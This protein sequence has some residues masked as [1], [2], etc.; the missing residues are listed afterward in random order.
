[1]PKVELFLFGGVDVRVDGRPMP[2]RLGKKAAGLLV[3]LALPLGR[4]HSREELATL[5]WPDRFDEQARQSLRQALTAIRRKLADA[6]ACLQSENGEVWISADGV[7]SDVAAFETLMTDDK[8]TTAGDAT[9]LYQD[10][11]AA[12][13]TDISEEFDEWLG[14]ERT[15]LNNL[16]ISAF[17]TV[18]TASLEAEE[19]GAAKADAHKLLA[20]DRANETAHRALIIAEASS[21]HYAAAL[22]QY[23]QFETILHQELDVC[24]NEE[25]QKFAQELKAEAELAPKP[26]LRHR[27]STAPSAFRQSVWRRRRGVITAAA[28]AILA[29]TGYIYLNSSLTETNSS[30]EIISVCAPLEGLGH[31]LPSVMI[32]PFSGGGNT[33]VPL[34]LSEATR[35]ALMRLSGIAIIEGPPPTHPD[36]SLSVR[37]LAEKTNITHVIQGSIRDGRDSHVLRVWLS[38][39]QTGEVLS[40]MSSTFDTDAP[41]LSALQNQIIYQLTRAVQFHITDGPQTSAYK[42]YEIEDLEIFRRNTLAYSQMFEISPGN[43]AAARREYQTVL[44]QVPEDAMAHNG[45]AMT[46][47]IPVLMGWS[48]S[49]TEDLNVA[50][51]H[52]MDAQR[53]DP[54]FPYLYSSLGLIHLVEG[55]IDVAIRQ[56][57]KAIQLN[58]SNGDGLMI[59][60]YILTFAGQHDQAELMAQQALRLRPYSPPEWQVWAAARAMRLNDH[61]SDALRCLESVSA[62]ES[63]VPLAGFEYTAALVADEQADRARIFASALRTR[64]GAERLSAQTL[65]AQPPYARREDY[66]ACV[67]IFSRAG[68]KD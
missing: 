16:A 20:L 10:H 44:D 4:K 5:F 39:G 8:E 58:D 37:E 22:R 66:D 57:R 48:A 17:E 67:A 1:M 30:T 27:L 36:T 35:A 60:S 56:A 51:T 34:L 41:N 59:L 52:A 43:I 29:G 7:S 50:R 31:S 14:I 15:R 6:E 12:R 49:P 55:D 47:L 68:F 53:A 63:P 61:P 19:M 13:L 65:C 38:D 3:R 33:E 32:M 9:V 45:F 28:V 42:Q 25:L 26:S 2:G 21:G 24:P 40:D 23:T 11:L 46:Y 64:L 62:E 18:I 54:D